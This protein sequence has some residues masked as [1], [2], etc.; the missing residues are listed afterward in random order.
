MENL[1]DKASEGLRRFKNQGGNI[2]DIDQLLDAKIDA[3]TNADQAAPS[4]AIKS[5]LWM[6]VLAMLVAGLAIFLLINQLMPKTAEPKQIFAQ[7]FD[8]MPALQGAE[9]GE[10]TTKNSSNEG[11]DQ[12]ASGN[13]AEA[14]TLLSQQKSGV[15][16]L[17]AGISFLEQE[18]FESAA[19]ALHAANQ[20]D[21]IEQFKDVWNWYSALAQIG[22]G[23]TTEAA[24][25]LQ[26]LVAAGK[27]KSKEAAEILQSFK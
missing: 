11:F 15:A 3:A 1:N 21:D 14:A 16:Q 12:Y 24:D 13:Y 10:T 20:F 2:E 23:N 8:V 18:K 26:T 17:Y 4:K 7:N 25:Y 5:N 9:R 6:Y 22:Q 27:Y 19:A